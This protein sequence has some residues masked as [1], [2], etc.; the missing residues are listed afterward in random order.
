MMA[1]FYLATDNMSQPEG[2]PYPEDL[3][4]EAPDVV[5]AAGVAD[6][7]RRCESHVESRQP[8]GDS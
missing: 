6:S 4:G 7:R 2:G 1:T 3:A 5:D 8:Q